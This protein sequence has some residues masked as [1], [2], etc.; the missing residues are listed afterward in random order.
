V[1]FPPSKARNLSLK[2]WSSICLPKAVG[3]LGF[4]LM[5][6]VN[7]S[8][9]AK[10]G[11]KLLTNSPSPWV[12]Q[13]QCKYLH[14]SPFLS[15]SPSPVCSWLWKGLLKARNLL[16]KGLCHR[17]HSN[18]SLPIWDSP[19]IPSLPSFVPSPRPPSSSPLS[20]ILVK[21]LFTP[22]LSWNLPLLS[23]LFDQISIREILKLPIP[24]VQPSS[25]FLW[26]PS[27][28]G[29][30]STKSAYSLLCQS[31]SSTPPS[32]LSIPSWKHLWK[33]DLCDRLKLF[34]WKI[35]W[36]L[37]PTKSRL[38]S[39][40]HIP[41]DE[42]VCPLC[43]SDLD[44]L[45]HLFFSC[46]FARIAW[47]ESFWNIDSSAWSNL[48]MEN[49]IKGILFPFSVFGIPAKDSHRFQ[50]YASVFCD[51]MW[52]YRNKAE[53]DGIIPAPLTISLAIKKLAWDH[54]S[55]WKA[56]SSISPEKWSPPMAGSFK[57]NFDTAIRD[58]YSAQAAVCR[59]SHG[60]IIKSVSQ[61][62]PPCDPIFGEALAARLA[63]SLASSLNLS[64]F[65]IEGDSHIVIMALQHPSI[66]QDWRIESLISDTIASLPSSSSWQARKV[67]RSA[68]FCA[69]HVA[70][71][72]AA[73]SHSGCIP[74]YF[75]PS[76]SSP[77]CSGKDPPP[78]LAVNLG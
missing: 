78:S 66:V 25:P 14:S 24:A 41:S 70:F 15:V 54:F 61:I 42:S 35:T 28:N 68:N 37:V 5:M 77:I 9:I 3:G 38:N 20:H 50:V 7:L 72:A 31:R 44:S 52:F 1:G 11:W 12:L 60:N 22:T 58:D 29:L 53:H 59:D 13:L 27:S 51:Q 6:D 65:T 69:H 2:S 49:W 55:A 76:P 33:L 17:I 43:R 74:T 8:L 4:R 16:S 48:G 46:I 75:P 64:K 63:A 47:K 30:F 32:P 45:S 36:N 34:L 62:N 67:N 19:W 26:T 10:L 57:V 23:S 39:V 40:F 71:W 56:P 18:S 21:D 73:R